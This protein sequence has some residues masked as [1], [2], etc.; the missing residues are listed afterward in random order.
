MED[1]RGLYYLAQPGNPDV[2][3]YTRMGEDGDIEFRLWERSHPEVWEKHQWVPIGAIRAAAELYKRE[4]RPEAD[5]LKLYDEAIARS[6][7]R[8]KK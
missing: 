6:L 3:V 7:L 4:R 2:R 5:P 1:E 8:S